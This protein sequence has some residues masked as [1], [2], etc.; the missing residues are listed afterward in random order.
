MRAASAA[1]A[2]RRH[3]VGGRNHPPSGPFVNPP[4][5]DCQAPATEG[6][7]TP[8]R[9]TPFSGIL[10]QGG[11]LAKFLPHALRQLLRLVSGACLAT[12]RWGQSLVPYRS[13]SPRTSRI[14]GETEG[15]PS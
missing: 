2:R 9:R 3:A 5:R 1:T 10:L 4:A 7:Q 6:L 14:A 15:S 13:S 11:A 12:D 8:L